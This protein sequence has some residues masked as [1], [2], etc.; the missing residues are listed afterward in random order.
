MQSADPVGKGKTD[1]RNCAGVLVQ[2]TGGQIIA[3]Q[4]TGGPGL[5]YLTQPVDHGLHRAVQP[6]KR[7]FVADQ[8]SGLIRGL[9]GT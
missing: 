4:I 6:P 1:G 2:I 7:R 5:A 3:G 8:A 9:P